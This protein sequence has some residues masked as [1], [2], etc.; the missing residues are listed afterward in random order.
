MLNPD[1]VK[2]SKKEIKTT[3]TESKDDS[4]INIKDGVHFGFSQKLSTISMQIAIR[5]VRFHFAVSL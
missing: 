1:N 2:S 3:L 4:F 5:N